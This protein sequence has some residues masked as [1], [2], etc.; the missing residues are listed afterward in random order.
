MN[1]PDIRPNHANWQQ[2][3]KEDPLSVEEA[4]AWHKMIDSFPNEDLLTFIVE[5]TRD[6]EAAW[7]KVELCGM[8]DYSN[9]VKKRD[10]NLRY[11]RAELQ[12]WKR[13]QAGER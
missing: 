9:L 5:A 2:F 8:R 11:E 3:C 10:A 1:T 7:R 4:A 13:W 6:E 12:A